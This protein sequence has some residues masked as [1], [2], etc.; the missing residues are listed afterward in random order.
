MMPFYWRVLG[1][2]R[3]DIVRDAPRFKGIAYNIAGNRS[4][5]RHI[6][7]TLLWFLLYS[8]KMVCGMIDFTGGGLFGMRDV[9]VP[10][11]KKK[12]VSPEELREAGIE[13]LVAECGRCCVRSM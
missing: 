5:Y 2:V 11:W 8:C 7:V 1:T 9:V 12:A 6:I 3:C 4:G 13:R 10:A